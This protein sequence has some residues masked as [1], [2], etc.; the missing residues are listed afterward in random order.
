MQRTCENVSQF[1]LNFS[2]GFFYIP[3]DK[4]AYLPA[5]IEFGILMLIVF[6][7]YRWVRRYSARQAEVAKQLE[8]RALQER[9]ERM[10]KQIKWMKSF[11]SK[12]TKLFIL[13]LI[14]RSAFRFIHLEKIQFMEYPRNFRVKN[15]PLVEIYIRHIFIYVPMIDFFYILNKKILKNKNIR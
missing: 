5:A 12:G 9:D 7:T 14:F 13:S 8:A 3:Q 6:A 11:V 1:L 2:G 4:S 15:P 10:A